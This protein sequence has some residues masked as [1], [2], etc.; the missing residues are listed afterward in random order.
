MGHSTTIQCPERS[1]HTSMG[2]VSIISITMGVVNMTRSRRASGKPTVKQLK[3]ELDELKREF[4]GF[5]NAAATDIMKLNHIIFGLLDEQGKI[6]K[7]TCIN[8]K[9]ECLRPDIEGLEQSEQCPNCGRSLHETE[10]IN[11][12]DMMKANMAQG[13]EKSEEE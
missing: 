8:C 7:M 12:Q 10:Q 13:S 11:L 6:S 5:A 2:I 4:G 1:K 9:E 3:A